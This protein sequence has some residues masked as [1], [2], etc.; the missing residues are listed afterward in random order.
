MRAL[1]MQLLCNVLTFH[2]RLST[3]QTWY[4]IFHEQKFM[5]GAHMF[6]FNIS[7]GFSISD[8]MCSMGCLFLDINMGF[9]R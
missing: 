3:F 6:H 2:S 7:M 1:D 4:W 8:I 9:P 5:P